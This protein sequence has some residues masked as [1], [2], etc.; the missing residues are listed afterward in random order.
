VLIIA[1][2]T[3]GQQQMVA[4][5][6]RFNAWTDHG[7]GATMARQRSPDMLQTALVVVGALAFCPS[8]ASAQVDFSGDWEL[9]EGRPADAS[10]SP[11]FRAAHVDHAGATLTIAPTPAQPLFEAPRVFRLDGTE[12]QYTHGNARGDETWV[13]VSRAHWKDASLQITT[14]TTRPGTGTWESQITLSLDDSGQMVI[15]TQEPTLTG[16]VATARLVY[17]RKR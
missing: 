6:Q 10:S 13:L 17:R 3:R 8:L 2:M 4:A 15:V 11:L 7:A 1:A 9:V 14:K 12:T 16:G 5:A